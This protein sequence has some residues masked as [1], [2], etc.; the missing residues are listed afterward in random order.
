MNSGQLRCFVETY[1]LGSYTRAA[2]SLFTS[3]Q[4]LRHTVATL[5]REIGAPLFSVDKKALVPT[6]V[7]ERLYP[8]ASEAVLAVSRAEAV[9]GE[10]AREEAAAL[11]DDDG[12]PRRVHAGGALAEARH[13]HGRPLHLRDF[14]Q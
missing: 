2:K 13:A 9:V 8:A 6:P 11:R 1:R 14:R 12:H 7:A 3:R 5:E 10:V 4:A